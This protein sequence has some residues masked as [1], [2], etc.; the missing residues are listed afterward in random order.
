MNEGRTKLD[1]NVDA[2]VKEEIQSENKSSMTIYDI[3]DTQLELDSDADV[4]GE[5]GYTD[6]EEG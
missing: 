4:T 3:V 5:E 6:N 2:E 1:A